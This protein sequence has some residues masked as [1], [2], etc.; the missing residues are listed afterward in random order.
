M[1]NTS[2]CFSGDLLSLITSIPY[3]IGYVSNADIQDGNL[4]NL[5]T[6]LVR[7]M[8]GNFVS[9]STSN[10]QSAMN[11]QSDAM[12]QRLTAKLVN[13]GGSSTYPLST[14]TYL[15]VFMNYT[16]NCSEVAELFMFLNDFYSEKKYQEIIVEKQMVPLSQS[17]RDRVSVL[18]FLNLLFL[19]ELN[20]DG[21]SYHF[22]IFS[23]FLY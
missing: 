4:K 7:N 13:A 1:C 22:L 17:V 2:P 11:V 15:I 8:E 23:C 6:A 5:K 18:V 9:A 14:Y 16:K 3:T 21:N 20:F 12:S 10:V 19:K